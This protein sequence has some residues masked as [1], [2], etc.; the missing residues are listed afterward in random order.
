MKFQAPNYLAAAALF[1]EDEITVTSLP[2]AKANFTPI[3]PSPPN[4][5]IPIFNPPL[6]AYQ[7]FNGSYKVIPAHRIGPAFSKAYPYGIFITNLSSTTCLLEYPP[8]V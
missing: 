1:G 8:K 3:S 4:P 6:V 7:C 2:I 5:A